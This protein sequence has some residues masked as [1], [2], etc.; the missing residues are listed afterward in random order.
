MNFAHPELLWFLLGLPFLAVTL[1]VI[2]R[3]YCNRL[4]TVSATTRPPLGRK[5]L[6]ISGML[7][8]LAYAAVIVAL[9][10]PRWSYEWRDV[11]RRGA[12]MV[13]ALDVSRSMNAADI[14][15]NRLE[16]AKREVKDLLRLARGDRVALV[17][18]SGVAFI[19]CPL[20]QDLEAFELFL[21]H[22]D[23]SSLP[24]QGTNI[25]AAL[26]QGQKALEQGADADSRGRA[27]IVIS[28]G[29][30]HDA[31]AAEVAQQLARR[32]ISIHAIGVGGQGAPIPLPDGGFLKDESGNM[33][34]SR[35]NEVTLKAIAKASDG[36]YVRSETGDFD[37]ERIYKE[38]IRPDLLEREQS[39]R[40]K[41]WI[42]RHMWASGFAIWCLLAE[43]ALQLGATRRRPSQTP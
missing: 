33:V 23:V 11:K 15:P 42:E 20:T 19:Q 27:I 39:T 2:H 16:R 8:C 36:V 1:L 6:L 22:A 21:D 38:R 43:F 25:S 24:V 29:E 31:Q 28:D 7:W 3:R 18:F 9:A 10:R 32:G 13:V 34:I 17:L 26:L 4:R 5:R 12:D 14:N 37:L 40:E 30:D 41:I 35:P